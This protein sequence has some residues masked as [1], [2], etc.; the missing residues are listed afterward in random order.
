MHSA[1][2]TTTRQRKLIALVENLNDNLGAF[3][4]A[5]VEDNPNLDP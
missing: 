5:I 1:H 4:V 3:L 2:Y